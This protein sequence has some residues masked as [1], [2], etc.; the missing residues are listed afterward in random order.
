MTTQ[1]EFVDVNEMRDA[2]MTFVEIAEATGYHRTTTPSGS[3]RAVRPG[4]G[5]RPR[6]GWC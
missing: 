2:G 3:R 1:E 4:G 6:S 5:R